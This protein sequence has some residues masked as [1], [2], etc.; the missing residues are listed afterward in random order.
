MEEKKFMFCTNCGSRIGLTDKF[1]T[2]CG[3]PQN[4]MPS[5][6]VNI[7]QTV[8]VQEA[9]AQTVPAQETPVQAEELKVEEVLA[10]MPAHEEIT[11]DSVPTQ[12]IDEFSQVAPVQEAIPQMPVQ[13]TPTPTP[14]PTQPV[15]PMMAPPV[16]PQMPPVQPTYPVQKEKKPFPKWLIGVIGGVAAVIIGVIVVLN[17]V[18][19]HEWQA[20]TCTSPETCIECGETRGS[21]IEHDWSTATCEKAKTCRMCGETKGEPLAHTPGTEQ[22]EKNYVTAKEKTIVKCTECGQVVDEEEKNITRM[23]DSNGF[24]FTPATFT[25]RFNAKL[26]NIEG[27]TL[28]ATCETTDT[29]V[30]CSIYRGTTEVGYV[31]FFVGDN[32]IFTGSQKNESGMD[33]IFMTTVDGA[34]SED[35]ATMYAAFLFTCD[36][37]TTGSE[38]SSNL[39][40][41]FNNGA[42]KNG[43]DYIGNASGGEFYMAAYVD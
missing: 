15:Q 2:V 36:P 12:F 23:Y 13:E 34:T 9:P 4:P 1:C 35:F 5:V 40:R 20:A 38:A 22:V 21:E 17:V 42:T 11:E 30:S 24:C 8:P 37:T 10:E 25:E 31:A 7:P 26:Q 33:S 18:C 29:L 19:F 32:V 39:E 14:M 3:K 43:I 28:T 6:E 27:N 16:P 41:I